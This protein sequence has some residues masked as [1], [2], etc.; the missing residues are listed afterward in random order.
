MS[1]LVVSTIEDASGAAGTVAFTGSCQAVAFN[2]TSDARL[3][4]NISDINNG[5]KMLINVLM[6][7]SLYQIQECSLRC[8]TIILL[9][10][11]Q[12]SEIHY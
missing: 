8:L 1:K 10:N 11:Q 12:K 6:S 2:A 3:K 9:Q 7:S 4:T 5:H